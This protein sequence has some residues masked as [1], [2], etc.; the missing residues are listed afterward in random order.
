MRTLIVTV[1]AL[2]LVGAASA[3]TVSDRFGNRVKQFHQYKTPFLTPDLDGDGTPDAVYL[4]AIAAGTKM[5]KIAS[6]VTVVS[7]VFQSKP[8]GNVA[9]NMALGIVFGKSG[10]KFLL[11]GYRGDEYEDYFDPAVW[12]ETAAPLH[13]VARGSD[14][15]KK[16]QARQTYLRFDYLSLKGDGDYDDIAWW[17]GRTFRPAT[18]SPQN[19]PC[20]RRASTSWH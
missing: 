2:L 8:L 17:N 12:N 20:L 11:T 18:F 15:F 7:D 9:E 13:A 3:G 4:V 14:E 16:C 10:K 1:A 19:R 5:V 6:D